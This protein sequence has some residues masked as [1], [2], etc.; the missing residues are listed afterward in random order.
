M[1]TLRSHSRPA[2]VLSNLLAYSL[3]ALPL[4]THASAQLAV[5]QAPIQLAKHCRYSAATPSA[6]SDAQLSRP[7]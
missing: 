2:G 4:P 5:D 3:L 6:A 7:N 1:S